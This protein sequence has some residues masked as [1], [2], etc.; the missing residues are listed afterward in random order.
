MHLNHCINQKHE[1]SEEA[2]E[3]EEQADEEEQT[4]NVEGSIED[5]RLTDSTVIQ[6]NRYKPTDSE[7]IQDNR[8]IEHLR[9][10]TTPEST[11]REI[12]KRGQSVSSPAPGNIPPN[13]NI[14]FEIQLQVFPPTTTT[15]HKS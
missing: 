3:A 1:D 11:V 14:N 7:T 12:I 15:K 4:D 6:N 8:V 5:P 2:E 9:D 10:P 13:L